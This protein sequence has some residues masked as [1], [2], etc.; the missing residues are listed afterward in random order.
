MKL[1]IFPY[2]LR[3]I[4]MSNTMHTLFFCYGSSTEGTNRLLIENLIGT[5][6]TNTSM[7]TKNKEKITWTIETD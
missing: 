4:T 2:S 1:R 7:T 3:I 5:V 6:S